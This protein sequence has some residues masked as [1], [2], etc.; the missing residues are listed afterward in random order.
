MFWGWVDKNTGRG[1]DKGVYCVV[2][3][4]FYV[5]AILNLKL[6]IKRDREKRDERRM[7]GR[8][9]VAKKKGREW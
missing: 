7:G 2:A 1:V 8:Q 6:K 9:P 4:I 3:T 5:C